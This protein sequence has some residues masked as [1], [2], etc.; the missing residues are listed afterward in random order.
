MGKS[1]EGL[2]P[3]FAAK[4]QALVAASGGKVTIE[5]GFRSVERQSQ[6]WNNAIAKYGSAAAARKWVAPPGKSNHNKGNAVDLGGG[7]DAIRLAHQLA[8]QFGLAFPM[9]HEPWH[10]EPAGY[11]GDKEAH[12]TPRVAAPDAVAPAAMAVAPPT[13]TDEPVG[14]PSITDVFGE[15]GDLLLGS[16]ATDG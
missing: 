12:T 8:P 7:P 3:L 2:D 11:R 1:T 14:P 6:L 16:G 13:P 4:I 5:S 10:V 15:L 9:G